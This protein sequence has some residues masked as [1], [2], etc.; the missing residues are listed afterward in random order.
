VRAVSDSQHS[1]GA[2]ITGISLLMPGVCLSL[3]EGPQRLVIGLLRAFQAPN[4][5][6][7]LLT[8]TR[9]MFL[10]VQDAPKRSFPLYHCSAVKLDAAAPTV[11]DAEQAVKMVPE[12]SVNLLKFG[13]DISELDG[14]ERNGALANVKAH[15]GEGMPRLSDVSTR[16]S[17][18]PPPLHGSRTPASTNASKI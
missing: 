1:Q 16:A 9:H 2:N 4:S 14:D 5:R 6:M 12:I 17:P 8:S 18:S 11:P 7:R 13:C 3:I 10:S 15:L